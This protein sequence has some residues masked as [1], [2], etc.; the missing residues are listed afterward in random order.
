MQTRGRALWDSV[1][2][3]FETKLLDKLGQSHPDLPVQ[4]L[5]GNYALLLSNPPPDRPRGSLAMLGRVNT[6][7]VAIACLRA[8]TGVGPQVLS[9]V[10]GLRKALED[11]TAAADGPAET[12]EA[13][14]WLASDEGSE[15]I[16]NSVDKI[17]NGLGGA[18]FATG[19]RKSKL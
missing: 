15:W 8:Q 7:L 18:N 13:V 9:H 17:V 1:Y 12:E 6:S 11:G 14:T 4:I 19:T 5:N 2:R 10:F 3:P 16:L